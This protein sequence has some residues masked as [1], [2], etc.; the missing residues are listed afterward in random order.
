MIKRLVLDKLTRW[1]NSTNRKP[2]IIRGA[3]Q[4]GKT[5]LVR[6]FSV[7]F[8]VFVELN[9][10]KEAERNLFELGDARRVLNAIFL[11]KNVVPGNGDT[12]LFIDEIQESPKAIALLRYFLEEVPDLYVIAAGSLLEFALAKVGNFPVG[13]VDYLY[14]HPLNFIEYLSAFGQ[15]AALDTI[16]EVPIPSF[17]HEILKQH[18]HDY[19]LI[20]GMPELVAQFQK[21]RNPAALSVGYRKIWQ[22]YKDD[23]EK[24]AK[25]ET[26][27]RVIRHVIDTAP[28]ELERIKFERFGNSN[29]RSREVGEALRSLDLARIIQLVYPGITVKPPLVLDYKKRPRLQFLDTGMWNEVL[30]L[31]AEMIQ[32]EDLDL[33][34][35]GRIIQHLVTQEIN[36]TF[37]DF[38]FTGHFW[39]REEKGSNSEVDIIYP[40][41][42]YLIP[43]EVKSGSSGTLRSLHQFMDRCGHP[44]AVRFYSGEFKIEKTK[45]INGTS[46]LLMNMPY[47]LGTQVEPYLRYFLGQKW[48]LSG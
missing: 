4:V 28:F 3:R 8:K 10:E 2:L 37:S 13:R 38:A 18:F 40:F 16:G 29:Y 35:K 44:F 26:E 22:A 12:L 15:Q 45:T 31:K 24:Y 23:V 41:D 39:V 46:F 32:V 17:A 25:N 6:V 1:K 19:A 43:I 48:N 47:Y 11:F 34:H 5:S 36:S 27:K 21:D 20:G 42:K 9:L 33:V 30:G 14:L 7:Q